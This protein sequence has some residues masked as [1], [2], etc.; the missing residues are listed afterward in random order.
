MKALGLSYANS[1]K[2][3]R[4]SEAFP[5]ISI[6]AFIRINSLG[7]LGRNIRISRTIAVVFL[8]VLCVQSSAFAKRKDDIVILNNGDRMTGEIKS[9]G[10]GVLSF[11]ADYMADPVRLDWRKVTRIESKDYFIITLTS[12]SLYTGSLNLVVP[13]RDFAENFAIH[14]GN[15]TVKVRQEEVV[16]LLPTEAEFLQQ[17]NGSIDYGFSY[18]S[19]NTQYQSQLSATANYRRG[20][21]YIVGSTS[22]NFSGQSRGDRTARY[23]VDMEYRKLLRERWFAGGVLDFLS[24]DEQSLELR[25]TAGGMFG[26]SLVSTER[27]NFSVGAGMVVTRERYNPSL[28]LDPLATNAEAMIGLSFNTFRFKTTDISSRLVVYPSV[29]VPGRMRIELDSNLKIE[30]FKD[31]YWSLNLYENF[32]SKPPVN[33]SRN[34]LGISSSF[35]WKF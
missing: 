26:R 30:I 8:A 18:T 32:D 11:K 28:G 1:V 27:S 20:S 10:Q 19:G 12:G 24:S 25:T 13:D 7:S 35:G 6:G 5:V 22:I 21:Q 16:K 23:N 15:N 14:A 2:G 33:A 9:L 34:D 4:A 31:F 17:L 29:T 3:D